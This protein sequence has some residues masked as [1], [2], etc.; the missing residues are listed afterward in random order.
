MNKLLLY[1]KFLYSVFRLIK[2]ENF[3][4]YFKIVFNYIEIKNKDLVIL[5]NGPSLSDELYKFENFDEQFSSLDVA[6]VNY[7]A[8]E[9]VFKKIQP[10]FYF[11]SD[12]QFFVENH[13][14]SKQAYELYEIIINVVN[15]SMIVFIPYNYWTTAYQQKFSRNQ[16]IHVIPFHHYSILGPDK[17]KFRYFKYGL[18]SGEWGTVVQNAIYCGLTLGYKCL[19]LYG[20]DHNFFD[21]LVLDE[22]NILCQLDTHY[23]DN[24]EKYYRK[25]VNLNGD[26]I[27]VSK[28]LYEYAKLF[29]GH[30]I[31]K[32][33]ADY[34]SAQIINHTKNSLIDSYKKV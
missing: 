27:S 24:G 3:K 22:N 18:G 26:P 17:I 29:E 28:F 13:P 10:K 5:G 7:L 2:Y 33:Y 34:L 14:K 11:L 16:F 19:H 1:L 20:V 6:F 8:K 9:K 25:I 23:Y 21:N 31:L 12:E 32:Q 30:N 4:N 15:W